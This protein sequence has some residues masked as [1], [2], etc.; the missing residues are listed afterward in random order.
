MCIILVLLYLLFSVKYKYMQKYT[1]P[2]FSVAGNLYFLVFKT[3]FL[4][5]YQRLDYKTFWFFNT[6]LS[7]RDELK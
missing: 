3:R 2:F 7:L 6:S 5:K 1:K 4:K